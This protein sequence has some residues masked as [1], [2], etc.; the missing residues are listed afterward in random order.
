MKMIS[1]KKSLRAPLHL[2]SGT[3]SVGQSTT[4]DDLRFSSSSHPNAGVVPVNEKSDVVTES[5]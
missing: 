3:S 4:L 1:F 5:H 2:H